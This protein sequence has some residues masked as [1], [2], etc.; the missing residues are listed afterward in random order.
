MLSLST[1]QGGSSV[2]LFPRNPVLNQAALTEWWLIGAM[3]PSGARSLGVGSGPLLHERR[4]GCYCTDLPC[5]LIFLLAIAAFVLL[6]G[7]GFTHGNTELLQNLA[8]G[9]DYQGCRCGHSAGVEKFKKTYFT[10]T[11][12]T[13]APVNWTASSRDGLKTVCT[14]Q[15]PEAAGAGSSREAYMRQPGLC[16]I[17]AYEAGLCTWYGATTLK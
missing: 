12:G 10:L 1:H 15:C 9:V 13:V 17:E 4:L 16:P 11:N 14:S 2:A 6:A 8:G 5:C 3:M 7:F